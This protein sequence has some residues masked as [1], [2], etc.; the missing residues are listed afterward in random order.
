[1]SFLHSFLCQHL[2]SFILPSLTPVP[3]LTS[4]PPMAPVPPLSIVT[5]VPLATAVPPENPVLHNPEM[6]GSVLMENL[7]ILKRL[8]N[9][10]D[11]GHILQEKIVPATLVRNSQITE[12]VVRGDNGRVPRARDINTLMYGD[13]QPPCPQWSPFPPCLL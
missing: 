11:A 5:H 9:S 10:D 12:N 8:R 6:L 3:P 13:P 2:Y 7:D 1:M 4:M